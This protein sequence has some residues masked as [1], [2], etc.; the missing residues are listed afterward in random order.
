MQRIHQMVSWNKIAGA[1]L[2][3][4][5]IVGFGI[6]EGVECEGEPSRR[7]FLAISRIAD[8]SGIDLCRSWLPIFQY[9]P[10]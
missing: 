2:A 3:I 7:T 9:G 1:A 6:G 10:R 4:T 5:I 8:A